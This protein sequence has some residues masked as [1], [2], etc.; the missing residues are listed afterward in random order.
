M[1]IWEGISIW[2]QRKTRA[3]KNKKDVKF[4]TKTGGWD[5]DDFRSRCKENDRHWIITSD[6]S[7]TVVSQEEILSVGWWIKDLYWYQTGVEW[8]VWVECKFDW[9]TD[10]Q[11]VNLKMRQFENL[12]IWQFGDEAK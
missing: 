4:C 8:T 7:Q 5:H 9:K 1:Y 10:L 2:K 3:T 11:E 12:K 6:R